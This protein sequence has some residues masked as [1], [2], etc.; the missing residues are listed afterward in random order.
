MRSLRTEWIVA[1]VAF[2]ALAAIVALIF[3]VNPVPPTSLVMSTASSTGPDYAIGQQYQR[4]L[5]AEG[6]TLDLLEGQG[7]AMTVDRLISGEAQ[8]GIVSTGIITDE[9]AESLRSLGSLYFEPIWIFYQADQDVQYITDL[10]GKRIGIGPVGSGTRLTALRLLAANGI[11]NE[12]S[13][14]VEP[15]FPEMR[16]QMLAGELDAVFWVV[17]PNSTSI[18][19]FLRT[20]SIALLDITRTQA[21][22]SLYPYLTTVII[23]EGLIDLENN[24]PSQSITVLAGAANLVVRDDIHPNLVR[25]L[26]RVIEEV[27]SPAGTFESAGQFPSESYV[28]LPLHPEA[29]RYLREGETFFENS[30]PFVFASILDRFIIVF[31]PLIP[32]LYPLVRG[33]P[34]VY[35]MAMRRR[36]LRWYGILYEIDQK[37]DELT[38]EQIDAELARLQ[39]IT[40]NLNKSPRP[41]L[42]RMGDFYNLQLHID[43]VTKRLQIRR[44]E[45]AV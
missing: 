16:E 1:L 44:S 41:P 38:T 21:Y 24:I 26:S 45:L 6:F 37:V 29:K 11:T 18:R 7:S 34:P 14:L 3:A 33:L 23:G 4:L 27:H 35:N 19:E 5:E 15:A 28:E 43:L 12:N 10:R 20:E 2:A 17:S 32:L 8:V 30:F 31:I 42:G 36:I 40:L 9:Q 13:T 39:E 25:L 22:R